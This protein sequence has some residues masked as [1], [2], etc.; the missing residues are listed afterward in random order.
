[1]EMLEGESLAARIERGPLSLDEVLRW[2][3]Q[4]AAGLDAAHRRGIVH[5]DLK[6]GN[7]M[8]TK[9]GAKLV[10]F[11]LAKVGGSGVISG[12][13]TLDTMEAKDRPLTEQGTILGTFQYMSPEQL[14]GAPAD[15][16][17][18]IFALG[19]LLYEM[20]TGKKAFAGKN[21]T[22]LIAAIV[23]SEPPAISTVQGMSPPALDHVVRKCL[24]KDP[25]DR[26][27]S[28]HDVMAQLQWIEEGGSQSGVPAVVSTRRRSRERWAWATVALLALV[29]AGFAAAWVRR[30]PAPQPVVRFLIPTPDG[31]NTAGPPAVS[32]D[33][34]TIAFDAAD[35]SGKRQIWIR[36]VDTVDARP[37]PGTEGAL[38]PIWSPD[39][40]F[41][42]FG[43]EGKLRK[44][45][46]AGGPVQTI[47]DAKTAADGTWNADG[48]ILFDGQGAD[49]I[50]RVDASG[51]VAK[52][53]V[54]VEPEKGIASVGWPEFLPDGRHYLYMAGPSS[55]DQMLMV[56][57]LG[58]TTGK[59]LFTVSSRVDLL[60]ARLP[61]LCP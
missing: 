8:I 41:V 49:P 48:V 25:D 7:V 55:G 27:Q 61:L 12:V 36:P 11:G 51:G 28:A 38:R 1:M 22:S 23:S 29:A 35:A 50:S 30:A 4:I 57:A 14:E 31:L 26:W 20:A 6:P 17:A 13:S 47:C 24:E 58:D 59:A 15:A 44:V 18:D 40:R 52:A 56:R 43:A 16:R 10:D 2:G 9:S 42:A 60:A 32:P 3:R 37:L 21:R 19:A 45:P 5:R 34:R 39:S 54:S 53:E 46:I 33:G